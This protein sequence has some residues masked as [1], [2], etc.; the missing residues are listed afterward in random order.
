[1]L[2]TRAKVRAIEHHAALDWREV[3]NFVRL[4]RQ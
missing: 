1:M 2:P 4:L 3:P